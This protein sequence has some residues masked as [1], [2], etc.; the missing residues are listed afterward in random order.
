MT[1]PELLAPAGDFACMVAAI[2]AGADAVYFG[3]KEL[4][5][6]VMGKNFTINDLKRIS[7]FKVKKYL[8]LNTIIYD[9]ELKKLDSMIKKAKP[10][11]DAVICWDLSVIELCKKHK[12]PFHISTQASIANTEAAKFYK[13]LGAE[14]IVLARELNLKQV[15]KISKIIDTEVFIHGAM[16]VSVSG[17]CFTSQF[18][19]KRSANRGQ[20]VQPCRRFYYVKDKDGNELKV[21]NNQVFSAKDLCTLP[22]IEKLKKAGIKSF[23]IEG[24]NRDA[25]YVDTVVRVYRKSI[26]NNLNKEQI[27]EGIKE[28]EKVYNK[29]FSSGFYLGTSTNDDFS[30][31]ENSASTERKEF[32]GVVQHYLPKVG[33]AIVKIQNVLKKSDNVLVIGNKTGILRHEINSIQINHEN[34]S[35]AKNGEVVAIKL[36]LCRKKD[37]VYRTVKR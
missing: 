37:E 23:K 20:C 22:F 29:Q 2:N 36:P 19:F 26:D 21:E 33:V 13:K 6:R 24:R 4:N 3:L 27:N 18:L 28:L 15:K 1:K 32:V 17:R 16:C 5:M 30:K 14:R 12:V 35:E 9:Y 11:I 7:K 25:D 34:V 8:T 10:Y 31:V